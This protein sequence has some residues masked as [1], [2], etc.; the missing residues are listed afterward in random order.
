MDAIESG[1]RDLLAELEQQ[2]RV[3]ETVLSSIVDFA[4]TLDLN[5]RFVYINKALLDFWGLDLASAV[6]KNFFD[7]QYPDEL[8]AKLQGQIQQVIETKQS[9]SDQTP[10]TSPAG[11]SGVYEYIL[12]PVLAADGS[13]ELVAGSTRD[14]TERHLAHERL[15]RS[16]ENLR[17][18]QAQNEHLLESERAARSTAEHASR[19]KDE[20]LATLSHELRTPLSAILGW[21]QLMRGLQLESEEL[22]EGLETI[23]RNAR[24]QTQLIEDLLDMSRIIS[25]KVRLDVQPLQL[26]SCLEAALE[27][28]M[29]AAKA[30]GIIVEK[31]FDPLAGS[32][33]ADGNRLQQVAW[34]LLSNAIKFT[35][36][37]GRV[38]MSLKRL[39]SHFELCVADSGQ[40]IAADF[41][42][43]VFNRFLQADASTSRKHSGLGLGLA[44]TK[45]LVEL[46]GGTIAVKSAGE[47]QGSTFTVS[48]PLEILYDGAENGESLP[49]EG[50]AEIAR[51][52]KN[53]NLVGLKILVVEDDADSRELLKRV[54]EES[55]AEVA[56]AA[57]AAEGLEAIKLQRPDILISDIG[58][59]LVDGYEFLRRV[60]EL[61]S[62]FGGEIAAVALTAFARPEDRTKALSVGFVAH[63]TKP[64]NPTEVLAIIARVAGRADD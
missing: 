49:S 12:T 14:I 52:W 64:A 50:A 62:S 23:E 37:G 61:D 53:A 34:N 7:L 16:E 17:V 54:L 55:R 21:T 38:A 26:V 58:M 36:R 48:L 19:M 13:V 22:K 60:R 3:V 47:L 46:H 33:L 42:P 63:L 10:Y 35:P 31:Y 2:R 39:D 56:T 40:G 32:I 45:Q 27:T 44:I 15:L 51:P 41:L 6:G 9:L 24:V 25:G 20:F 59:P 43:L 4:Y 11:A 8:A 18:L 5:G 57:S 29:P 28:V 30:K 1:R